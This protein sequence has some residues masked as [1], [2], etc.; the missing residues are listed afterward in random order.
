MFTIIGA[1]GKEYGPVSADKIRD[2]LAG[3]RANF[4]TRAKRD[5]EPDW[6]TLADFAEFAAT[7]L[8][9]VGVATVAPGIPVP[10]GPVDAKAYAAELNARSAPLDVFECLSR[11]FKLWTSNFWPLVGVTLLV[12]LAQ[13][14]AGMIP[15]LGMLVGFVLNGV[16]YGGLYYY[17]LGKIRG[18]PREVG[19]AFAGFTKAFV[20]LMLATI[21]NSA[22]TLAVMIPS[23]FPLLA[24]FIQIAMRGGQPSPESIPP[25]GGVALL[26]MCAGFLVLVYLAISWLFAFALV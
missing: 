23:F 24:V 16:F 11:S 6:K 26:A 4:Q 19:D 20:P 15:I 25:L 10:V 2:W 17:Y 3:G 22:I 18:E 14:I 13:M 8:P 5:G 21:L 7:E 9:P 1:D 12:F